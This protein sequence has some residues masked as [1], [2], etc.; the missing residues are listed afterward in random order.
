MK[1]LDVK[2]RSKEWL[3]ERRTKLGASDIAELMTGSERQIYNL[4]REKVHGEERFVTP[5]MKQGNE[6][7]G[8]ARE[9]FSKLT[10]MDFQESTAVHDNGW[11]MASLDG[12]NSESNQAIEIKV[13]AKM[14]T[15]VLDYKGYEKA[16]WQIQAHYAVYDLDQVELLIYSKEEKMYSHVP[17][18]KNDI[19][20]LIEK[21][22][23]F[24]H[25]CMLNFQPP[26]DLDPE[27]EERSDSLWNETC[28]G[29]LDADQ[30][31]KEATRLR[32][33]YRN[34]LISLAGDRS[35][36]G[37]GV[38]LTKRSRQG[39]VDYSKIPA[40]EGMDLNPYRKPGIVEWRVSA[41]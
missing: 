35:C 41:T 31:V 24:Y 10:G 36:K 37:S 40:L 38:S 4:W 17:K 12:W 20:K 34:V 21:G 1:L 19:N 18:D 32:D 15:S 22:S 5:A 11:L 3:A 30:M 7:E 29:W 9:W 28:V 33:R 27:H 25:D 23:W 6:L 14:P 8:E 39:L 13:P 2:Q 16:Y 26:A